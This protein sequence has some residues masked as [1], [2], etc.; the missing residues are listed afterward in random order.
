MGLLKQGFRFLGLGVLIGMFPLLPTVLNRDE[1]AGVLS[2]QGVKV[3]WQAPKGWFSMLERPH[4]SSH[5]E[6]HVLSKHRTRPQKLSLSL[7]GG[8]F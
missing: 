3:A 7:N 2:S 5:V 4:M 8:F 1:N 6:T